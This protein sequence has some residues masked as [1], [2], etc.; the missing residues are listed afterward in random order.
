MKIKQRSGI[1]IVL[2]ILLL[3]LL[4]NIALSANAPEGPT[5]L[6]IMNSSRRTPNAAETLE[7]KAGNVTQLN[8]YAKTQT[9]TWQGYYGNV[10][11]NIVLE[12]AGGSTIYDWESTSPSGQLYATTSNNID[13]SDG[14]IKCYNFSEFG[15]GYKNL[16]VYEDSLGLTNMSADGI[17][18]TFNTTTN[19]DSFY[20]SSTQITGPCPTTYLYNAT[21]GSSQ[22]TYQELMLYDVSENEII[23]T[24]IIR[25]GGILGFDSQYWDFQMII[26]ENGHLGNDQTTTYYFYV[27]LE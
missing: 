6:T 2:I 1:G 4:A 10:S 15:A 12:E 18:E 27:A 25:Q 14:N 3:I 26:A 9:N 8:I 16:N 24:S 22:N 17:N 13:F 21:N 20:V 11:G 23:Y 19:Y 5:N 7:A